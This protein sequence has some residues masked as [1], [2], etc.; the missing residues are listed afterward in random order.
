MRVLVTGADGFLGRAVRATLSRHGHSVVSFVRTDAA[1]A[2]G[3]RVV[4]DVRDLD[5]VRSAVHGVDA[6]CHLAALTRVRESY[7]DPL[8][9]WRTNLVGTLNILSALTE[10]APAGRQPRRLVLASTAAVYGTQA[11]QP[12]AEDALTLPGS[13]YGQSKLVA[14]QTAAAAAA[15]GAIGATSLRAFNVAG[16]ADS[17]PDRDQTRLIPRVAAVAAGLESEV[18][19]NGDGSTVRDFVHV[20]DMAEA[21]ALALGACTP[22]EWR[23]YNIGSGYRTSILDVVRSAEQLTGEP[24][25]VRHAPPAQEPP[26]LLADASRI[27]AELGWQPKHS[28][29]HQ[30]LADAMRALTS[31]Y[32]ESE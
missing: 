8:A 12:V 29:L 26:V 11:K 32:A 17:A 13:P 16:A 14:D 7:N 18:V 28:D 30:I 15:T 3:P 2:D 27:Q 21:F 23:A 9:Y 20:V 4:G 31:P 24:L 25:P 22:G 19:V 10:G 1:G 6:V 5:S